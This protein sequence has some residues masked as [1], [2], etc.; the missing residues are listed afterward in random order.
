[1]CLEITV[2]V[3]LRTIISIVYNKFLFVS[4]ATFGPIQIITVLGCFL[5]SLMTLL[6]K[7]SCFGNRL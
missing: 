5:L 3:S 4:P 7:F 6:G 2:L 1:M